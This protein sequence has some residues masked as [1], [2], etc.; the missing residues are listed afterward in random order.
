MLDAAIGRNLLHREAWERQAQTLEQ[1]LAG[2]HPSPLERVLC[3]RI[4]SCW[5]DA[6]LAD[7][8]S[9]D[10]LKRDGMNRAAGDY[11]LRRQDRAHARFVG[12]VVALARV[13]RLLAPPLVAQVNIAQPGAQQLNI[14]APAIPDIP[15]A[16]PAGA[17]HCITTDSSSV[18]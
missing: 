10:W 6:H 9:A 16:I 15:V 1:E 8:S 18:G 11:C 4:A 12:A 14:A 3:E 17:Q 5:L 7:L 13:R 2:P